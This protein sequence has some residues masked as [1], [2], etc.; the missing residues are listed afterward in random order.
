MNRAIPQNTQRRLWADSLGV[1]GNPDCQSELLKNGSSIG[2]IAHIEPY[3]KGGNN[4]FDNLILLC[5]NCHTL[6]DKKM[7]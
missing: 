6:V 4:K 3:A 2:N 7:V 1:C 5:P